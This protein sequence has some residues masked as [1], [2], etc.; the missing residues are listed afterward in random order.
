MEIW[1]DVK[2]YE[3]IYAVS[4]EGRVKSLKRG[5]I[6]I[7]H[8]TSNDYFQVHL[9]RDGKVRY[10]YLH[11]VVAEAFHTAEREEQNEVNHIDGDRHNNAAANLEWCTRS[12]NHRTAIY[13]ERQVAAKIASGKNKPVHQFSLE[14]KMMATFYGL[15]EA[16]RATGAQR[17]CIKNCCIG[18]AATAGGYVWKYAE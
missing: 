7:V 3:G 17:H 11:R 1:K 18:K 12:E 14:G 10:A 2:G 13:K 16:S 15:H 6:L 8:N 5:K 4:S 9:N